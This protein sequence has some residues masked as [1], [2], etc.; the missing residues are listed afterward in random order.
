MDSAPS[1]EKPDPVKL[2]KEAE[3]K[4]AKL[5]RQHEQR[6][7]RA[8]ARREKR[9]LK[10][11]AKKARKLNVQRAAKWTPERKAAD[12]EKKLANRKAKQEKKHR[13]LRSKADR[14]E[15]QAK[16]LWTDAQKMRALAD[17]LD[18]R[19][20]Q[21][22][23][24][25]N[26]LKNEILALEQG[27]ETEDF[28]PLNAPRKLL[29]P[30]PRDSIKDEAQDATDPSSTA[31]A[32]I[33]GSEPNEKRSKKEE[34][35]KKRKR[36]AAE[37]DNAKGTTAD[38][39]NVDGAAEAEAK[40]DARKEKKKKRKTEHTGDDEKDA[41]EPREVH[42]KANK[43]KKEHTAEETDVPEALNVTE[44]SKDKK[45]K[46]KKDK[47][48]ADAGEENGDMEVEVTDEASPEKKEKKKKKKDSKEKDTAE[49]YE[50]PTPEDKADPSADSGEQWNVSALEGGDQRQQKF[51]RLLG[52]KKP[53]GTS[54]G[55]HHA[56]STSTKSDIAK[57][58]SDLEHQFDLG[59]KMK[60][61]GHSRRKGLGA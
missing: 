61:E 22:D 34:K 18:E 51:L 60:E 35:K 26:K 1:W 19:K 40:M 4:E 16:K 38:V 28:I 24:E 49:M 54:S 11:D 47:K 32:P 27:P 15:A 44:S 56:G 30:T 13:K 6:L 36:Q 23:A 14:Y 25:K 43:S 21:E 29:A 8:E 3:A 58:Q 52:G 55:D 5:K 33:D 17:L 57:M 39:M 2:R 59:M 53:N 10:S 42:K 50:V 41:E 12:R 31:D 9:H 20:E 45:K 48:K 7:A 37:E 46:K